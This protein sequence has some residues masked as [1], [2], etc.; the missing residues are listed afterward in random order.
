M[1]PHIWKNQRQNKNED[2]IKWN[3]QSHYSNHLHNGCPNI[4][5]ASGFQ[6]GEPGYPSVLTKSKGPLCQKIL[7]E[8]PWDKRLS[9]L[10]AVSLATKSC[11][12]AYV[13]KLH[14]TI[15]FSAVLEVTSWKQ[16]TAHKATKSLEQSNCRFHSFTACIKSSTQKRPVLVGPIQ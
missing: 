11:I 10:S 13:S 2:D 14:A 6:H 16:A 1:A 8:S 7:A 9:G 4:C 3:D 12:K 5:K 15:G